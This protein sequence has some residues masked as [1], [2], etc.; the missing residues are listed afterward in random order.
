M[1]VDSNIT[2]RFAHTL[3]TS[4]VKNPDS[5]AQEAVFSIVLPK[6]AF[7]S[8]FVMSIGDKDYEAYVQEKQ[9]AQTTYS[10]V[11]IIIYDLLHH[12]QI[13][14]FRLFQVDKELV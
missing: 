5:K 11:S 13:I 4:K 10:Q 14:Y 2:N 7:I 1:R 9:K 3:V 8:K 6:K 12:S